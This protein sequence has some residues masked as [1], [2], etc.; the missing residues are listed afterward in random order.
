MLSTIDMR[1]GKFITRLL[2]AWDTIPERILL[3]D[4]EGNIH[5]QP[6]KPEHTFQLTI[7]NAKPEKAKGAESVKIYDPQGWAKRLNAAVNYTWVGFM[8]GTDEDAI[9]TVFREFPNKKAFYD[10]AAAYK[11]MYGTSLSADLDGDLDWSMNWRAMI[12]KK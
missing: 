9:K 5:S 8:P 12:K 6:K 11:R 4:T 3:G 7:K 1:T 2:D 10:T